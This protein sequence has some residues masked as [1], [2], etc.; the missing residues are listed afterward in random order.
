M[1]G[2]FLLNG[3]PA[4]PELVEVACPACPE[5]LGPAR[6]KLRRGERSRGER[7][8]GELGCSSTLFGVTLTVRLCSLSPSKVEGSLLNGSKGRT[9]SMVALFLLPRRHKVY[10][11]PSFAEGKES[12]LGGLFHV[13]LC[14][15]GDFPRSS[16]GACLLYQ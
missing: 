9:I 8:R 6:D 10:L 11:P 2:P 16:F 12:R 14:G 4:C 15:R 13:G 3:E 1:S 7:S 5:P